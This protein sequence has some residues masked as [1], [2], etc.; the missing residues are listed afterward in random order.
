MFPTIFSLG[1]KGLGKDTEYGSSLIVMAIVGGAVL[2]LIFGYISD[3]TG[4]L[5]FGH[6]VS[7]VCFMVTLAFALKGH[8]IV[9]NKISNG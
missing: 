3:L 6:V 8:K 5:Q 4:S 7:L 9:K 1:I 2:P